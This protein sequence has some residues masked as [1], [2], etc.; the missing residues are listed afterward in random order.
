MKFLIILALFILQVFSIQFQEIQGSYYVKSQCYSALC[1]RSY[2]KNSQ[3]LVCPKEGDK[4][5]Q[6]SAY[7]KNVNGYTQYYQEF[8][9]ETYNMG[10]G[11]S[12]E[13]SFTVNYEDF[14]SGN[15]LQVV[16]RDGSEIEFRRTD[17][18]NKFL[19]KKIT[20]DGY[21]DNN[22]SFYINK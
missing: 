21:Y 7:M 1:F 9:I 4:R 15:L 17:T 11:Y 3:S 14:G 16:L 20:V 12:S 19:V 18:E 10:W 22:C 13:L 2:H 6:A 5:F 8:T